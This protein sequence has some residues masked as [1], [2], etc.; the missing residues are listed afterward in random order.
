MR[1]LVFPSELVGRYS[2]S[3]KVNLRFMS[4]ANI[5]DGDLE[6]KSMGEVEMYCRYL[7]QAGILGDVMVEITNVTAP[8]LP[9]MG[10]EFVT[11]NPMELNTNAPSM[12]LKLQLLKIE[13][14]ANPQ[15]FHSQFSILISSVNEMCQRANSKFNFRILDT[16][17]LVQF[18]HSLIPDSVKRQRIE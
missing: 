18:Q 12:A 13:K 2:G 6:Y 4:R 7:L 9:A 5:Q 14:M 8:Y 11:L 17:S 16:K 3:T 1:K 10:G 15:F